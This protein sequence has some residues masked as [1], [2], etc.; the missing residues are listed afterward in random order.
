V[1]QLPVTC[2][3]VIPVSL[4]V[5][6]VMDQVM[7]SD[8]Q[9][10][11]IPAS[12]LTVVVFQSLAFRPVIWPWSLPVMSHAAHQPTESVCCLLGLDQP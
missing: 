5:L 1:R 4:A 11:P 9:S 7:Y 12:S 8:I 10:T 6:L 2:V 3:F